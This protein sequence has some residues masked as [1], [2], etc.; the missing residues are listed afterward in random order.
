M[1]KPGKEKREV[2]AH[3]SLLSAQP[4][5]HKTI[6]DTSLEKTVLDQLKNHPKPELLVRALNAAAIAHGPGSKFEAA[7]LNWHRMEAASLSK[8]MATL[9]KN[10]KK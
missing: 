9:A 8:Q 4:A 10:K 6:K 7:V 1:A 3:Y 5:L 2:S